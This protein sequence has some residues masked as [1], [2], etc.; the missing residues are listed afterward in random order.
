MVTEIIGKPMRVYR[1]LYNIKDAKGSIT[2]QHEDFFS[3]WRAKLE[4]WL[5]RHKKEVIPDIGICVFK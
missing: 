2:P 5:L 4:V 3:L 1:V